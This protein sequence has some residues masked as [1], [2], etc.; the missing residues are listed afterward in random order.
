MHAI[1]V[2]PHLFVSYRPGGSDCGIE[3]RHVG[4]MNRGHS[5]DLVSAQGGLHDDVPRCSVADV[6]RRLLC[7]SCPP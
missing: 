1:S 6:T 3:Y 5:A 7:C 2:G 4:G